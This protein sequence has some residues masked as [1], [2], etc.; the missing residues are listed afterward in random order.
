M[1]TSV[2]A[3]F[4]V[5]GVRLDRP[6][7]IRRL[8]HFGF[9]VGDVEANRHVYVDLLGFRISD[10]ANFS[11]RFPNGELDDIPKPSGYFTRYGTD[12]HAFVLFSKPMMDRIAQLGGRQFK[13]A[14]T[15]NQITWQVGSLAE[16]GNG[17]KWF[18]E[19]GV[20]IQR[21][22]RDMPGSHWHTYVY[23]PAGD[24]VR[25]VQ[26]KG[27]D[28]LLPSSLFFATDGRLLV[29]PGCYEFRVPSI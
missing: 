19:R 12:H 1:T 6:F 28:V 26:F 15:I 8:G 17:A 21:T 22:G 10:E 29:T 2:E 3:T 27:A 16:V 5:G 4:D 9:N 25:T 14:V 13:P 7:K 20:P 18:A 24:K 23:D 11:H